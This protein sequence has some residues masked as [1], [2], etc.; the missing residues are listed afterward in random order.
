[1]TTFMSVLN[2]LNIALTL[3]VSIGVGFGFGWNLR[4]FLLKK[5]LK[6]RNELVEEGKKIDQDI[7]Q[8]ID[9]NRRLVKRMRELAKKLKKLKE[10]VEVIEPVT[11]DYWI[12]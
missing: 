5:E 12:N 8:N 7:K 4:E 10:G 2:D 1:M 11:P 9:T 6:V 3:L